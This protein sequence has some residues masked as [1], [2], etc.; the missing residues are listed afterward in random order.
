MKEFVWHL[1]HV[2]NIYP[3]LKLP[4][5]VR[6]AK[7]WIVQLYTPEFKIVHLENSKHREI[8]IGAD[9]AFRLSVGEYSIDF[10]FNL[11]GFGIGLSYKTDKLLALDKQQI[12]KYD[13]NRGT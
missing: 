13:S 7:R 6:L 12:W 3:N 1:K 4:L 9:S 11:L 5:D 8:F 2:H 10:G